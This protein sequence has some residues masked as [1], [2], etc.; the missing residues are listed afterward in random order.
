MSTINVANLVFTMQQKISSTTNEQ[1]LFYYSKVLQQLRSGKVYVVN[2]VTDLPTAAANVGELYYVVLNT[3][4]YVATVTGWGV[5]GT[6]P[7][8]QIWSWGFNGCGRL[9]DNSVTDRSSPVREI[10]SSTTW[11]QTSAA[12]VNG[13]RIS[14]VKT[15][16]SLWTWGYNRYG[17][18]GDNS[19]TD[20]SSPVREI[21]SST[22]WCQT[23]AGNAHTSALKT[24]S[25]LWSWGNASCG[26]LGD[27][28]TTNR[29]SPVREI[30]SSTTWCQT[31][32][33]G[34]STGSHTSALKTDGTLWTWGWNRW[35]QLGNNSVTDRSSPVRESSSSTTWCQTSAGPSNTAAIKT[36]GTLWTWGENGS[37]QLGNNTITNSSNPNIEITNSTNWCRT[38][39]GVH[40]AAIKTDGSLWTWGYNG[41]GQLGDNTVTNRSSPVREITNSTT[42][43]QTSVGWRHT[44]A[45]KIYGTLWTW[46]GNGSGQLGDNTVTNRSSPVR[47]ITSSTT[48]RQTS[49][50]GFHTSALK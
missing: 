43:C 25:T 22:T 41:Q 15:D 33:G 28:S 13:G 36:N 2:A 9:G 45:L 26:T 14:A 44:S 23:S 37:G 35:G 3:S 34:W 16:G 1:D 29:S 47:E 19:V 20:R 49:A 40:T 4:L 5:I 17:R 39:A 31:S 50:G 10:T 38:S 6:T 30:T 46:G 21:T 7:L 32:S 8:N 48:W 18:L 12:A 24:D 42:W 27:N 11:C